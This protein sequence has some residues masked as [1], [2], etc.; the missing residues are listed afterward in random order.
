MHQAQAG[1]IKLACLLQEK[2]LQAHEDKTCFIV[3]GSKEY[4]EKV[5]KDLDPSPLMFGKFP[6]TERVSEKYLG[7]VLHSGGL[8]ESAKATVEDRSGKIRGATLEIK[9]IV[10]E[11]EMQAMG[12]LM[13]AWESW[14]KALVPLLLS[15]AGTWIGDINE[16]AKLCDNILLEDIISS[17]ILS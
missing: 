10:E 8:S 7:Q 5:K 11:F 9:S 15:G 4:K 14:E 12:G 13:A 6:V 16:T 2:G 1:N 17:R 3:F